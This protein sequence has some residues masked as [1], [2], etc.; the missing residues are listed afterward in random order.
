MRNL[1]LKLAVAALAL[2]ATSLPARADDPWLSFKGGDGPGKGKTVVLVTGDEEYRSEEAMPQLAKMLA[3]RHGFACTVLFA[4]GKDGTIDPN[5]TD[6]IPGLDAL[7]TADLLVMF[8]RFRDLP[9]DQMKAVADYLD[10]GRPVIGLRTS[11]H[12]FNVKKGKPYERFS[13]NAS[14]V[15]GW[16][17][18]F[19]RRVLGE[20]WVNHHGIHGKQSTLG[21]VAPGAEA[22][23]ILR[24][25]KTGD[26]Y[27]PTD[28]YA[29]HLPL[30]GDSKPLVLGQVLTGMDP[31]DPPLAGPKND[32][33]MPVAWVKTY[34]GADGKTGR[35]FTTTM[36]ASQ[37]LLSEGVRRMLV[38]ACYWAVGL[39]DKIPAKSDVT[40]VGN[41]EPTKF[42]F[43]GAKKGVKVS[44]LAG[45]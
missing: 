31:T 22:H 27:G 36:G 4:I 13:H 43:N 12:A 25:V 20:T 18:G 21:V 23:P 16:A 24:G 38:N 40:L 17:G 42:G 26:I 5:R 44:D 19:G 14:G 30:P 7:K 8:T 29:V 33:M 41:Y 15:E 35:V 37:D 39:E 6:N 9:D 28:V 34:E 3:E 10:S 2:I 32:P 45:H 11:T 1:R